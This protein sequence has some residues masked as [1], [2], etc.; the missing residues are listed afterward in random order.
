[1]LSF[2]RERVLVEMILGEITCGLSDSTLCISQLK[3]HRGTYSQYSHI[4]LSVFS[5]TEAQISP[6][7][8]DKNLFTVREH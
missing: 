1:M 2:P 4:N 8:G 5:A 7:K 6:G 3:L